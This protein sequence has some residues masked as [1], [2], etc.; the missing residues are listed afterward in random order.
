MDVQELE[1][2][3]TRSDR[4]GNVAQIYTYIAWVTGNL[5]LVPDI[6]T[7]TSPAAF[8]SYTLMVANTL[9]KEGHFSVVIVWRGSGVYF[10]RN[11]MSQSFLSEHFANINID[12]ISECRQWHCYDNVVSTNQTIPGHTQKNHV[13]FKLF[14][15]N[16]LLIEKFITVTSQVFPS[17]LLGY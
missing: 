10:I 16:V 13:N 4:S 6:L 3:M 15:R 7:P 1:D 11:Q 8:H 9:S 2:Q 5:G 17:V 12:D 14:Y